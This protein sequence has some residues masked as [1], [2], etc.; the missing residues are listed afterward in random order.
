MS[1]EL[2][3]LIFDSQLCRLNLTELAISLAF[4]FVY[5]YSAKKFG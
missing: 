5:G 1:K 4:N 3:C 2:T